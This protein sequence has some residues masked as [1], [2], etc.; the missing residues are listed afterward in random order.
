[1]TCVVIKKRPQ[2]VVFCKKKDKKRTKKVQFKY[3]LI[4]YQNAFLLTQTRF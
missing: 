1:M 3:N 2:Y 4:V